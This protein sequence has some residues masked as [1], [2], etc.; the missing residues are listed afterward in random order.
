MKD[1]NIIFGPIPS[2]RLGRSLGIN[3]IPPKICSYSC[4]YCQLGRAIEMDSERTTY[5]QPERIFRE[6]EK[7]VQQV[8]SSEEH[9]DYLTFVP[10][11]E[12]T[13]DLNLGK[14]VELLKHFGIKQAII[15]N[16]SLIH[17]SDVREDLE[18]FDLVSLKVDSVIE[19]VWK[20]VDRPHK[21]LDLE[22]ILEGIKKFTDSYEGRLITETML[23]DGVNDGE[24]SLEKTAKFIA[25]IHPDTA[26]LS[27]PTRPPARKDV[28][29]VTEE[30]INEAF[31]LFHSR[32]DKVEY[33]L[34]HE[35]N[36]FAHSG[37]TEA[38]LLSITA[39]HPM[40]DDSVEEF[41]KKDNKEWDLVWKLISDG[42]LL[43]TE[44][45]GHKF[46]VRK[47]TDRQQV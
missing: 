31:Q 43:E 5:Y 12:S 20:K 23:I 26:Y 10:D 46:Y 40:R 38:D 35:G 15:S 42:K 9:I 17:R 25:S 39:V 41:L 33:L 34:G 16:A 28:K 13:L 30:K 8:Q 27:I 21:K 37:D 19:P 47:L 3:N 45:G 24:E 7:K 36:A 1:Q 44:F 11:G 32:M 18:K 4:I 2:R 29:P 22:L 14:E 6:V